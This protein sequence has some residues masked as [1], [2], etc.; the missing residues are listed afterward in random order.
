MIFDIVSSEENLDQHVEA[1]K[2]IY[3]FKT[4]C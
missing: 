1:H 4:L 3:C 2:A